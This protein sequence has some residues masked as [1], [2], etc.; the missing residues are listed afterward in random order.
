VAEAARD[1]LLL[2]LGSLP[3]FLALGL[4]EGFISPSPAVPVQIKAAL[5]VALLGLFVLLGLNPL[6][7]KE[8]A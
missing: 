6:R 1:A 5:G 8:G 3:W 4:V 2:L 7:A